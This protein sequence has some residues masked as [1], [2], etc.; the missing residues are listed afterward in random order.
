MPNIA[1]PSASR[2]LYR[3]A[4]CDWKLKEFLLHEKRLGAPELVCPKCGAKT[5]CSHQA[6]WADLTK[7]ERRGLATGYVLS[8]VFAGGALGIAAGGIAA[9]LLYVADAGDTAALVALFVVLAI[10]ML[11]FATRHL[12]NVSASK[13]RTR[14]RSI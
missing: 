2:I 14:G 11:A 13:K 4:R 10:V 12:H 7:Q 3:C 9:L 6:E 1:M 8:V 5:P